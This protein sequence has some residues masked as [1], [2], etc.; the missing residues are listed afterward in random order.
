MKNQQDTHLEIAE[1]L[2]EIV[3]KDPN[4]TIEY[5][6]NESTSDFNKRILQQA[7]GV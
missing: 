6:L 4:V 3:R 7:W 5:R 1:A 2:E